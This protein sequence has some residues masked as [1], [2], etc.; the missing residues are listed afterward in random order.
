M[1][2]AIEALLDAAG[3][4]HYE[5]SAYA[6]PERTCR[7]NRNYWE[8][9]DYLGIGA[10]AHSKLSFPDRILRQVRYKQPQQYLKKVEGGTPLLEEHV[11]T[12][13]SFL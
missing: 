2:D 5:T 12:R 7:H 9:G 1:Q 10:G 6:Q 4:E 3:Y 8:F 11:V 13:S